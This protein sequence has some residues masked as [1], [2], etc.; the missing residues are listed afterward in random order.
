M[1]IYERL[2]RRAKELNNEVW[3]S[4]DSDYS[5]DGVD[6]AEFDEYDEEDYE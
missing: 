2:E 4:D 1:G 3:G 5:D 6:D